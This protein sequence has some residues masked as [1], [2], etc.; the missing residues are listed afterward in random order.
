MKDKEAL[1][2]AFIIAAM[3]GWAPGIGRSRDPLKE[4]DIQKEIELINQKKSRLSSNMRRLV[5][6]RAKGGSDGKGL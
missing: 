3:G 5:I 2:T 4:I 1:A 6:Q